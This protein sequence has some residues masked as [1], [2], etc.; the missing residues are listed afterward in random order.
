MK[1]LFGTDGIR[2]IANRYPIAP[3]VA[4][5][6]GRSI[7]KLLAKEDRQARF[8]IGQDTR[9][10]GDML[11]H[12][13]VSGI[14]SAGAQGELLGVLPTPGIAYLTRARGAQGGI[15]ISASHNPYQDNGIKVFGAEGVKLADEMEEAI[16]RQVLAG[17]A[18]PAAEWSS[19]EPG[20]AL[21]V[22][23]AVERYVQFLTSCAGVNGNRFGG[24]RLVLDCAHGATCEVAPRVFA[25][26]GASVEAV[27]VSPD[28]KNIN[29]GCGSQH[30]EKLAERVVDSKAHLGLAFDGDGDRMIAV[31]ETG[32][33]LSGDRILAV[34]AA[35][36][37]SKGLLSNNVVVST[38]MS[39]NGLGVALKRLG[40][41]HVMAAVGDRYVVEAMR[42]HGAALGGEDSGHMVFAG[43]HSTGDG[44]LS[45]LKL[46]EAVVEQGKPLSELKGIMTIFPQVLI[47]VE[48]RSKPPV[49]SVPQIASAIDA[50]GK[51][52]GDQG[53]VLVRYSGTQAICRVMVEGP[54]EEKTRA[55]CRRIAAAVEEALG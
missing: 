3:E 50:V 15:V 47:N 11:A 14:S 17:L 20:R 46:L 33:V 27:H 10:S 31:D 36:L 26:L 51:E 43:H 5:Q 32:E 38:V 39:N 42:A 25:E 48:V 16:E 1:M 40:V 19:G 18:R 45:G 55:Y 41:R 52:L 23:D 35:H 49:E 12:A 13:L 22:A 9:I 7:A 4:L 54:T 37:K 29:A 44:I 21:W 30:P 2:G 53:R 8:V 28:G 34:C 6:V 24:V